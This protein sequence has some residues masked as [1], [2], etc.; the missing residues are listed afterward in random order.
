[1]NKLNRIF[2]EGTLKSPQVDFNSQTGE[3]ILFGRSIPENAAKVYEPLLLWI[4]EYVDTPLQTTN[5]RLNLEYYNTATSI[6]IAKLVRGLSKISRADSVL[7]I[8]V[9][10]DQDDFGSMDIE[11]LKDMVFSLISQI[12]EPRVSIGIKTYGTS[13]DGKIIPGSTIIV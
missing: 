10:F 12:E 3:L 9:Y 8:H 2:T 11:E 7:F 6:W 1:M 13:E 5:F 4:N